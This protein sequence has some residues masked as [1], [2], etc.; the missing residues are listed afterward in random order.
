MKGW[1]VVNGNLRFDTDFIG[2]HKEMLMSSHHVDP[3]VRDWRKVLLITAAWQKNEF[4]EGHIKQ[5]LES[6]GIPSRFDGGFDQNIQNL[7]LYHE[8]NDLR[9]REQDLYT[10]YH[11]KQDVIIRTK[12]FYTRKNDEFLQ[13]LRDQVGMIRAN[14]DGSSLAGILDYDVLRHRSELSHYNEA[15]LFYHYCCQDVQD[16]MSKIIENDNLMLKICNEIDDYFRDRSRIDENPDYIATRDRLRRNILSSNSIF[17]FGGNLPVL[18]NRLKFFNLRDVFQEALYRGTNF[19]TVSAGS[20]ALSDKVIVFDDFGNDQSDG[21]KKEFEFFDRGLGLV[22]RVTLFPHCMDRIQT[23]DPDNLSY[24]ANRFSTGPCVGLNE[25]SF[26]LVETVREA[27][28]GGVRDRYV[29]VG[30][31]DGVYVFDRS[32]HKHCRTFGQEIQID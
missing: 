6:I 10:R 8:F 22:N 7:G 32:G 25:N 4:Q 31:R 20:M 2:T 3:D 14:F 29:S 24:L 17:L 30:K 15:E 1:I 9:S 18:L 5:A 21:G 16:T 13:I 23:D 26:L 11:R 19:Y 12:E 27:E 28:T